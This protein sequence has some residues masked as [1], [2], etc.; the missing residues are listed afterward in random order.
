MDQK[1]LIAGEKESDVSKASESYQ[2]GQCA[3]WYGRENVCP[4]GF[5]PAEFNRGYKAASEA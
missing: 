2:A 5:D 3:F 1:T 4:A